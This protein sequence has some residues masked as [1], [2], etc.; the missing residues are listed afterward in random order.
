MA[1]HPEIGLGPIRG[2]T[3]WWH[4]GR[5]TLRAMCG[6]VAVALLVGAPVTGLSEHLGVGLPVTPL[7]AA[8]P[9]GANPGGGSPLSEAE[10]SLAQGAGPAGGLPMQCSTSGSSAACSSSPATPSSREKSGTPLTPGVL[11]VLPANVSP[12]ARYGAALAT[13]ANGSA[14]DVLLFGGAD[15]AG[16]VYNDTWQFS[17]LHRTWWN[18]TSQLTCTSSTCPSARHDAAVGFDQFD[19][20]TFLF[21]G[22]S[23]PSPTWTEST[24]PCGS[25]HLLGDTWYYNDPGGGLGHWNAVNSTPS[26]S[27]RFAAG[28]ATACYTA[29]K[30]CPGPTTAVM[31]FGGC[32]VPCPMN[33]TWEFTR[34]LTGGSWTNITSA[35]PTSPSA[36]YGFAMA[37]TQGNSTVPSALALV[38]GC[39]V[40]T[41]NCGDG[42]GA[43]NDTWLLFGSQWRWHYTPT[44]GTISPRYL[45][46]SA[47]YE[48]PQSPWLMM[49]FGG[50]AGGTVLG[51]A[52]DWT[53]SGGWWT[54]NNSASPN[55]THGWIWLD[56]AWP[57]GGGTPNTY[58]PGWTGS[59]PVGPAVPRYDA[60]LAG[61]PGSDGVLLFGGS[62]PTGSSLGD[63][64]W[65]GGVG[66]VIFSGPLW[67]PPVPSAQYGGTV[68]YD[69]VDGYDVL[70]GGCGAQ[71]GT[72]TTWR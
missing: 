33:D 40:W 38:G 32:G 70:F 23:A 58:A 44:N 6:A 27:P 60:M 50:I 15:S 45:L 42:A 43:V 17:T 4:P 59:Y 30:S 71:C 53:A 36:R 51:N 35:L 47:A 39:P 22:C 64:W 20:W 12:S 68:A 61:P 48:G 66:G 41:P 14:F 26:P 5:P 21:G 28:M 2:R 72:A 19:G 7:R 13:F 16:R 69:S 1:E 11:P 62:S 54:L 8:G 37:I 25:T 57:P 63:T 10:L 65:G 24:P 56:H 52:T 9:S 34:G 55:V 3:D 31:L 18:V 67:P 29:F 46:G 49:V